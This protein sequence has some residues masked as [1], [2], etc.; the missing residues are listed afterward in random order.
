VRFVMGHEVVDGYSAS[1]DADRPVST[2]G[3]RPP[4]PSTVEASCHS[5][6]AELL[7]ALTLHKHSCGREGAL[8]KQSPQNQLDAGERATPDLLILDLRYRRG[9][10]R[11]SPPLAGR[12]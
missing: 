2:R 4:Y 11:G 10:L 5:K 6:A 3:G 12:R 9:Q 7:N 1:D 8:N